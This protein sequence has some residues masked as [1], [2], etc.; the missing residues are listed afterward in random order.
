MFDVIANLC[1]YFRCHCYVGFCDA[2]DFNIVVGDYLCDF[3]GWVMTSRDRVCI[4]EGKPAVSIKWGCVDVIP[5][6]A[7][8]VLV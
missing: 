7:L 3:K 1:F 8:E 5:M 2:K 6:V 4:L